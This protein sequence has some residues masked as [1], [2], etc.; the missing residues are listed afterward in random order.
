MILKRFDPNPYTGKP[1]YYKDNPEA[2]KKRDSQRM[3]VNGKEISK[4]HP[5][6]KPG[7]YKSLDDAWSHS[8][9]ES[10]KQGEV[11]AITNPAFPNW[12][13]IGK[14]VNAD[15]RCN[16]YQTSSPF[17]D[18]KIIARMETEDRHSKETEMHKIFQHF[19]SERRG[20]WFKIDNLTAIKIFNYQ[21][22]EE[23]NHEDESGAGSN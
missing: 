7:R 23:R 19:A 1:M 17:R 21:I 12:I 2:V 15:D 5:L 14:A 9:I 4:K 11:Y 3:Y 8:K 22:S 6:H 13:K 20:E 16:G 18:Y 10:T